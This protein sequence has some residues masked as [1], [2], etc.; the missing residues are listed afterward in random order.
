VERDNEIRTSKKQKRGRK[1]A[2]KRHQP[3]FWG[4]REDLKKDV[5]MMISVLSLKT[6]MPSTQK[7]TRRRGRAARV[8]GEERKGARTAK[9]LDGHKLETKETSSSNQIN[10]RKIIFFPL[11]PQEGTRRCRRTG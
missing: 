1:K 9:P 3:L 6:K 8:K 2:K 7:A 11:K 10:T 5:K 4:N